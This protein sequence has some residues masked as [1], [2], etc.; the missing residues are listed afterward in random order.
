[1]NFKSNARIYA[2]VFMAIALLFTTTQCNKNSSNPAEAPVVFPAD[3][4]AGQFGK[5]ELNVPA[6]QIS[7]TADPVGSV[8]CDLV[9]FTANGTGGE[10]LNC[11]FGAPQG[12]GKV[13]LTFKVTDANG[14]V[15]TYVDQGVILAPP[16]T[17]TQDTFSVAITNPQ[18][19]TTATVTN[20]TSSGGKPTTVMKL[21]TPVDLT[22]SIVAPGSLVTMNWGDGTTQT[23]TAGSWNL[24]H[25]W[26]IPGFYT[27]TVSAAGG[28]GAGTLSVALQVMCDS[29][30]PP[31]VAGNTQITAAVNG[32]SDNQYNFTANVTGGSG[33]FT[34]LW[35]PDGTGVYRD[36]AAAGLTAKYY[37]DYHGNRTIQAIVTDTS[38]GNQLPLSQLYNFAIPTSDGVPGTLQGPQVGN[39]AFIQGDLAS[40][41]QATANDLRVNGFM[42]LLQAAS[43]PAPNRLQGNYQWTGTGSETAG[44][45]P[46][47]ATFTESGFTLINDNKDGISLSANFAADGTMTIT[48]VTVYVSGNT[49]LGSLLADSYS[50]PSCTAKGTVTQITG[51]DTCTNGGGGT[52]VLGNVIDY[53]YSCPTMSDGHGN[54]LALTQGAGYYV[55]DTGNGTCGGGGQEGGN[56]PPA[57]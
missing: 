15:T 29:S 55:V 17:L 9:N 34:T 44:G 41:I 16:T 26:T 37:A 50:S 14:K 49:E 7:M 5:I 48:N 11:A 6:S 46:Y 10:T 33:N 20:N 8:V 57:F 52:I 54:T 45:S 21:N 31:M 53:T 56:A 47:P 3:A 32:A 35:S 51:T 30:I 24:T 12:S 1:M 25:I 42:A 18:S 38:C 43:D 13:T 40:T 22:G 19:H 2:N 36:P 4:M 23:L 28:G 27:L 39:I